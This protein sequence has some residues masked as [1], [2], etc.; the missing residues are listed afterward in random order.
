MMCSMEIYI[1]IVCL[2]DSGWMNEK[3]EEEE[4]AEVVIDGGGGG[5]RSDMLDVYGWVVGWI[6]ICW[7]EMNG[8]L[9]GWT[10][11]GWMRKKKKKKRRWR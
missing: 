5:V 7:M 6:M 9:N 3:E 4:V 8:L 10:R 1:R 2:M 11:S